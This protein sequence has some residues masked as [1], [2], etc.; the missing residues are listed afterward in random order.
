M[1][2]LQPNFGSCSRIWTF[3]TRSYSG[4]HCE[5]ALADEAIP[6]CEVLTLGL[7]RHKNCFILQQFLLKPLG[8][9]LALPVRKGELLPGEWQRIALVEFSGPRQREI[10][11]FFALLSE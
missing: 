11:V 2:I 7:L 5:E 10:I 8:T 9:S 6:W 1:K 3:K 4:C